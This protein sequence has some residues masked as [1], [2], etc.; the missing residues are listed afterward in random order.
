LGTMEAQKLGCMMRGRDMYRVC[1]GA[2]ASSE[3][4]RACGR[5]GGSRALLRRQTGA[6][7]SWR[8]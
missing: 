8:R 4:L 3:K 2:G 5:A 7:R 1:D 6:L